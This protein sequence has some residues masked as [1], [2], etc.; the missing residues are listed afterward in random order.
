MVNQ[1]ADFFLDDKPFL[2]DR[3][4]NARAW[5]RSG[6]PDVPTRRL[7]QDQQYGNVSDTLDHPSVYEDW[8]G[9]PGD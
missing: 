7:P 4:T 1:Q 3:T 8:S 2:L 5:S 6:V 9:G